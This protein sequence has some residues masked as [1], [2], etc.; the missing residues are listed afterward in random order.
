M[1]L[2]QQLEVKSAGNEEKVQRAFAAALEMQQKS[3]EEAFTFKAELER[4]IR[5]NQEEMNV[6]TKQVS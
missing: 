6:L 4:T 5:Q 3:V 1:Q 2:Q